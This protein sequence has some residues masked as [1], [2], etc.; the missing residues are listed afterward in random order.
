MQLARSY[1]LPITEG[2]GIPYPD[3]EGISEELIRSV[4][5]EFYR[6]ARRDPS[7]GPVFESY[8]QSWDVHLDRMTDFWSAAL[9]RTG[10][11][12]GRPVEQHRAIDNLSS[13]HFSRWLDLF[14]ATVH[15]LCSPPEAEAFLIRA[16]RMR[17]GMVKV[18]RLGS[19]PS[20]HSRA[21]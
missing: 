19:K 10:R 14:D 15:D 12:S 3:A 21:H 2:A 20:E 11:Y 1:G 16:R 7:L 4:V 6:R 13:A 17:E 9:L 5:V 18:L 8:V